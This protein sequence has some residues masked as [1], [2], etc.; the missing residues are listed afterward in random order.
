MPLWS[1]SNAAV[2]SGTQTRWESHD[3]GRGQP[4][5]ERPRRPPRPTLPKAPAVRQY[6]K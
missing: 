5:W 4:R 2:A 1:L 6:N 3:Q